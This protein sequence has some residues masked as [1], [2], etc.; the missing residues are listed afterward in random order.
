VTGVYYLLGILVVVLGVA[1]SIGLHELGHLLPA[2]RFGVRCSQYMIGFGPTVWSRR[3]GDTE[4]GIKAIPLGGYVRMIGMIPPRPGDVPGRL[5]ASTTGRMGALVDQARQ[6]AMEELQPGDEDRVFYKLSVPKKVV[7]MLGGPVMN[8][9]L[10]VALLTVLMVG[11]GRQAALPTLGLVTDCAPSTLPT[12]SN[13]QPSCLPGDPNAPAKAAGLQAGDT[14]VSVDGQPVRLWSEVVAVVKRSAGT[15]VALVVSR[16]GTEMPLTVVPAAV[17]RPVYTS[18][19]RVQVRSDGSL[20]TET[21][22]YVGAQ[23]TVGYVREPLAAVPGQVVSVLGDAVGALASVPAKLV[24]VVEAVTGQAQ[25]D[26]NGPISVIGVA[27]VG[28]EIASG[29]L[30]AETPQ[31]VAAQIAGLLFGLNIALFLFN[32]LPLLPLD[33]GQVVGALWE[34]AKRRWARLRGRPDPGYV[35]VAKALPLSYAVSMAFIALTLLLV[36]ADL[37]APVKLG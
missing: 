35:D 36:Y 34:G 4:Y 30:G 1:L 18:D 32:L 14:I 7:V 12:A 37:V 10:A 28:G 8:L 13:P 25:R 21:V 24:G 16:N 15:P 22:G 29:Q 23:A 5:R 31:S 3:R 17:V 19:G 11:I 27:R 2:K 33:G 20:V 9:L 6:E 26:P